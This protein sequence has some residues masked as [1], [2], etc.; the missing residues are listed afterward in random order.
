MSSLSDEMVQQ[1]MARIGFGAH[2]AATEEN[3][4]NLQLVHMQIIPYDNMDCHMKRSIIV[5]D[6][7]SIFSKLVTRR[8]GGYCYEHNQ[9]FTH[10]LLALGYDATLLHSRVLVDLKPGQSTPMTHVIIK[11]KLGG[12]MYID[13]VGGHN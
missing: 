8:R 3:L 7:H 9:L 1:Y 6:M 11:E 12:T 13:D 10:I 5:D 2:P 4:F